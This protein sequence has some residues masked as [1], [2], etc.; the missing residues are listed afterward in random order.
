MS[1]QKYSRQD[2]IDGLQSV[3]DKI[4]KSPTKTEYQEHRKDSHPSAEWIVDNLSGWND[5]KTDVGFEVYHRRFTK[6][7]YIDA[8]KYVADK[9]G[10]SPSVSE[11]KANKK[12]HHPGNSVICNNLGSWNNAK[13]LAGLDILNSAGRSRYSKKEAINALQ[14]VAD[15]IG[16][17]PSQREY[18]ANKKDHHPS[19][20]W[21]KCN[22]G[23]WNNAKDTAGLKKSDN[24]GINYKDKE[25]F[26]RKIKK[27]VQCKKCGLQGPNRRLH[28]HHVKPDT[29]VEKVTTMVNRDYSMEELRAEIKKCV[30]LC[31]TCHGHKHSKTVVKE[32][33][34]NAL[35]W[36]ADKLGDIP[37]PN[38]YQKHKKS[39]HPNHGTISKRLDSWSNAKET[40]NLDSKQATLQSDFASPSRN[41][42]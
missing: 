11:Y 31:D 36:V 29:K 19:S 5:L 3:A 42:E 24:V 8:I 6:Q 23:S 9:I 39:H 15:K 1:T 30:I 2:A 16:K 32:D 21:I 14:S 28:F 41:D 35:Q 18:I 4:G 27:Q 34:I 26:L 25:L 38:E 40:V 17:S 12:D 13:E 22:L 7:D 20:N 33:C 10:K 37:T